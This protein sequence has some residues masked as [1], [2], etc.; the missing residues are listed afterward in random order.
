M[1]LKKDIGNSNYVIRRG[2]ILQAEEQQGK[3]QY[4]VLYRAGLKTIKEEDVLR[5]EPYVPEK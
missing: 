4:G 3:K 1:V 2:L 5:I